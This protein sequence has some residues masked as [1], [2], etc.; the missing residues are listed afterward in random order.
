MVHAVKPKLEAG[1]TPHIRLKAAQIGI[2]LW[3]NNSGVA[4]NETGQPVR[5]G[6]C[7]DSAELNERIKAS[8][9]VGITP[10]MVTP[11]MVGTVVGIF[12]AIETKKEGWK[13]STSDKRAVA[14]AAFHDIVRK[15]GGF[16]GFATSVAEFLHIVRR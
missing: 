13:F 12:T 1:V 9:W 10:V 5:F 3:R 7:N 11:Q 16:A 15:A 4:F 8:D 6:L 2:D 14:Q